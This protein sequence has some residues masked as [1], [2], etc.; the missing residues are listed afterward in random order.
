[1]TQSKPTTKKRAAIYCRISL[2]KKLGTSDEREGVK[3]Q[4]EDCK[5]ICK[6]NGYEIYDIYEDNSVSAHATEEKKAKERA[7]YTRMIED[8]KAGKFDVIVAWKLDRLT[9]SVS[10]LEDMLRE[11]AGQGLCICTTDLGG[12][13]QDLTKA[14]AVML[15]QLMATFAQFESSRKSER[16]KAAIRSRAQAGLMRTGKRCFGYDAKSRIIEEEAEIVRAIYEA[17]DRGSS[18]GAI[19]RALRGEDDGTLPNFPTSDPV[20]V[21]DA[22]RRG[23]QPP[24]RKW[25]MHATATILRNPKYAGY[26]YHAPVGNDGK[27]QPYDSNWRKWIV[28]DEEGSYVKGA[29]FEAIVDEDLWWRVQDRRDQNLTDSKGRTIPRG[30][31]RKSIGSG[32]YLCGVCGKP[33]KSGGRANYGGHDYGMTYYCKG[34]LSRMAHH[35]DKFVMEVIRQRLSM[36]DLQDLLLVPE[37]NSGRIE[38]IRKEIKELNGRI[39][40][41][42]R[43]YDEDYID[44]KT[45]RRKSDKLLAKRAALEDE[46]AALSLGDLSASVITAP[47]PVEAFDALTDPRQIAQVI[48]A[49][50]TVEVDPHPRGKRVTAQSLEQEVHIHWKG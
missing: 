23:E 13:E 10:G 1:M 40:Q 30:G 31:G 35:V 37:D 18:M 6:M 48:D 32:L 38:E 47:N 4:L 15:A 34:D 19:T 36:P 24:N 11:L 20:T 45:Y 14:D 50:C 44:A 41:T 33:L 43:D 42:E 39:A 5:L 21:I 46:R 28:R 25:G 3:R 49:L 2:D 29:N 27:H 17:Y 12:S 22:K 9:R 16:Q 8:F 7:G 26:M